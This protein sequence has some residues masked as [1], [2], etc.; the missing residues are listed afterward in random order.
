MHAKLKYFFSLFIRGVGGGEDGTFPQSVHYRP[1]P[2]KASLRKVKVPIVGGA[3]C[4]W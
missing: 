3:G 4:L 1:P 2:L